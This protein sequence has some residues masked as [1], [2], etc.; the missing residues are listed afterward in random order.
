MGRVMSRFT[1]LGISLECQ[2]FNRNR[3]WHVVCKKFG[4][5][6]EDNSY[7]FCRRSQSTVNYFYAAEHEPTKAAYHFHSLLK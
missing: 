2:S 7:L 3:N 4:E 5:T 1:V 6:F